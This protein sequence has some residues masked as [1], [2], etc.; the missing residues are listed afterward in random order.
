MHEHVRLKRVILSLLLTLSLVL[1]LISPYALAEDRDDPKEPSK[2]SDTPFTQTIPTN[3]SGPDVRLLPNGQLLSP[4]GKLIHWGNKSLEN[5][6]MDIALSPDGTLLAVLGRFDLALIDTRLEKII[7]V[8]PLDGAKEGL[9][10][11]AGIVWHPDGK[12]FYVPLSGADSKLKTPKDGRVVEVQIEG[13]GTQAKIGSLK[14]LATFAPVDGRPALPNGLFLAAD[15]KSLYVALNGLKDIARIDLLNGQVSQLTL[16]TSQYPYAIVQAGRKLYV[17]MWG[18]SVPNGNEPSGLGGWNDYAFKLQQ[19]VKVDPIKDTLISGTVE[20]VDLSD[21]KMRPL[22]TIAVGLL[23]GAMTVSPDGRYVYVANAGS[24]T[25]S[26]IDT[27]KDKVVETIWTSPDGIPYG[28]S[29]NALTL[30]DDGRYL[31]VADGMINAV[32]VIEL[33]KDAGGVASREKSHVLGFLPTAQYP[34]GL[35]ISKDGKKLWVA[36][37]EGIGP[38]ATTEDPN[39]KGFKSAYPN[40]FT[41]EPFSTAGAFNAHKE[42]SFVSVMPLPQDENALQQYTDTVWFTIHYNRALEQAKSVAEKPRKDA[43]PKPIPDRIGEPSVFKHVIY[44]VKENRTYDQVLGDM[45]EG[46]GDPELTV[47]GEKVTPNHHA[48]AREFALID[49]YYLPA[50]SSAEGHPWAY[51]A[52]LS[53]Y[54]QKNVR[55]WFRGYPHTILDAMVPPKTGYLWDHVLASGKTFRAYGVNTLPVMNDPA[56]TWTDLFALTKKNLLPSGLK[57]KGTIPAVVN[58]SHPQYPGEDYRFSDQLR[59]DLFIEDL[60]RFEASGTMPDFIVM[61]L[62]NDHAAGTKPGFP[63]PQAMVADNDLALG[64]I[65]EALSKSKFWKE[66]VVFVIEDDAQ[67]GWDHV[68]PFRA[69]VFVL[70]PYSRL[71]HPVH[72]YYT[73]LDLIRTMEQILGIQPMNLLDLSARPMVELFTDTPDLTPYTARPNQISLTMMNPTPQAAKDATEWAFAMLGEQM[74]AVIDNPAYDDLLNRMI[75]YSVKGASVP[76]PDE[77]D[78]GYR[79]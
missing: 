10:V 50:K 35:A 68:S 60:K 26:V 20:V 52:Y 12:R 54:V 36:N 6:A 19:S 25:V 58:H 29:P 27:Q 18:G 8:R 42:E 63:T 2:T 75:W 57:I 59:A 17:S 15:Q 62:P 76:Y 45:P 5:H 3:V 66:T 23:P 1:S 14:T 7:D 49:N 67:D 31:L 11:Y 30:S 53:D 4:A 13:Q 41:G 38:F 77:D 39:D 74:E 78:L 37:L 33:G 56:L 40:Y 79:F 55:A 47:F 28:A 61:A 34:S 43:K 16:P 70:S 73:E 64:R 24:D 51:T 32:A 9:G 71:G 48:L 46:N 72:T 21:G 44:I 69:P 65:I 22:K